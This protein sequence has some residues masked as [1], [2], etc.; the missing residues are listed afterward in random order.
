MCHSCL[1]AIIGGSAY[2]PACSLQALLWREGCGTAESKGE[3]PIRLQKIPE[4]LQAATKPWIYRTYSSAGHFL[5]S[6]IT[7]Y[8]SE[9]YPPRSTPNIRHRLCRTRHCPPGSSY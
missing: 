6:S 2:Q 7:E 5:A 3:G 4:G 1:F 9:P 8:S